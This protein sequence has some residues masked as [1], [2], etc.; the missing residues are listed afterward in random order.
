MLVYSRQKARPNRPVPK[1]PAF[2][3]DAKTTLVVANPSASAK[4]TSSKTAQAKST[5]AKCFMCS[6]VHQLADC[7]KFMASSVD[8]RY[9]IVCVH[10]LCMV[11]F[12]EGHMSFKCSSSCITTSR[13]GFEDGQSTSCHAWSAA[14]SNGAIRDSSGPSTRHSGE[15]PHYTRA[16]RFGFAD[17]RYNIK[18]L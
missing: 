2:R 8:E 11:C 13:P 14:I 4:P 3:R 7:S 6:G 5:A 1:K 16:N 9:N 12:G 17:Q 10:R 15:L 18:L